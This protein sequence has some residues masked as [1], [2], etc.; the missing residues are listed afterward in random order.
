MLP[1]TEKTKEEINEIKDNDSNL[2]GV[3]PNDSEEEQ[4]FRSKIS[5]D[6]LESK[7][8]RQSDYDESGY[9]IEENWEDDYKL[10]KGKGLQWLTNFAYRSK[11]ARANRPN[12]EDNF[13]FNTIEVQKANLSGSVPDVTISGIEEN[14]QEIAEKL[15]FMSRHNDNKN[16]LYESFKKWVHDFCLSGPAI[17]CVQWDNDW[18]GGKGPKRWIG[19]VRISRIRKEEMYFDPSI[20]DLEENMQQCS[21]IIRRFR[22]KLSYIKSRWD[23]GKYVGVQY[24]EDIQINEGADP[25]QTYL[26]EYWHNGYPEYMP[27]ERKKELEAKADELEALGDIYKAQD[28]RDSTKGN[29][30]GIHVAYYADDVLLEYIPYIYEDGLYPFVFIT[31]YYDDKCH[32][33]FGECRNL[34]IPQVLHNKADEIEIEAMCKEG[35]GGYYYEKGSISKGQLN[36]ILENS[37]KGGQFLEVDRIDKMKAREG[38]RVPGSIVEYKANKERIINSIQPATTIQQ[39]IS[40]GANVPFSTVQELGNRTDVRMKQ[41]NDKFEDFLTRINELRINRFE[42]FYTED[43]YYRIRGAYNK[44]QEGTLNNQEMLNSWDREIV[45]KENKETGMIE[46]QVQKEMFV[47]EFDIKI[48]ILSEKPTDRNYNT[49]LAY[50]LHNMQLL[51]PEDLFY[52]LEEGKLPPTKD[53]LQHIYAR[54]PIMDVLADIQELPTEIQQQIMDNLKQSIQQSQMM[55]EQMAIQEQQ[56]QE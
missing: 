37:G 26:E 46:Q 10:Y 11:R 22:K 5:M 27:E 44:I 30:E 39:G 3:M 43:R 4:K 16:K 42:Q 9:S 47:P 51:S 35:L 49:Q 41:A 12:S 36:K 17:A 23:K 48:T 45:E 19:D 2:Q 53:I 50:N 32:W 40:P 31:K 52:V 8:V 7:A 54:Q 21:Y 34:S 20:Q 13:I 18:I 38:V 33:G 6:Y 55:A 24:N 15:T 1:W 29:I 25:E 28:Y 14:D 56:M